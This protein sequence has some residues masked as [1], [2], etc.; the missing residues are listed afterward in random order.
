MLLPKRP[1]GAG[2]PSALLRAQGGCGERG[3]AGKV[4]CRKELKK[5][6]REQ[7]VA[8]PEAERKWTRLKRSGP[9]GEVRRTGPGAATRQD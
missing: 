5:H 2:G 6:D 1:V 9:G 3:G 4:Q 8:W 7:I